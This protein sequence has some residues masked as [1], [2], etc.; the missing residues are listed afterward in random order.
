MT[1]WTSPYSHA[2]RAL[3]QRYAPAHTRASF[4]QPEGLPTG[5]VAA[6]CYPCR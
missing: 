3:I 6:A 2:S 4:S 5:A 1:R